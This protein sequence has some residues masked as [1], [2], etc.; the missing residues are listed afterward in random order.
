M[1]CFLC[2]DII[3]NE[4]YMIPCDD[5]ERFE[6]KENSCKIIKKE[7]CFKFMYNIF[8]ENCLIMYLDNYPINFKQIM[9]REIYGKNVNKNIIKN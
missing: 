3:F 4:Y 2:S 6:Y 7:G 9:K 5:D 1:Y 8:C